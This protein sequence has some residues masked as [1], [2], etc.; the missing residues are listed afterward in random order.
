[1]IKG[2]KY[3]LVGVCLFQLTIELIL[4]FDSPSAAPPKEVQGIIFLHEDLLHR[5]CGEGRSVKSPHQAE[6]QI[7][8]FSPV[9][10]P[11]VRPDTAAEWDSGNTVWE[12][13][14]VRWPH[15]KKTSNTCTLS[16]YPS[17]K[18]H[19]R[20]PV[21]RPAEPGGP[22]TCGTCLAPGQDSQVCDREMV[23]CGVRCVCLCEREREREM[24]GW[25]RRGMVSG[26]EG[27]L[28]RGE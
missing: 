19:S 12:N 18:T 22:R 5:T 23:Q 24:S 27:N 11:S 3:D 21:T 2:H 6:R 4:G 28:I 26:V 7:Q 1:M 25:E 13:K 17:A 14:K 15:C 10:R 8:H 20:E 9:I 16:K